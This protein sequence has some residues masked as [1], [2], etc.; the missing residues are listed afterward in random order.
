MV[1]SNVPPPSSRSVSFDWNNVVEP[2]L[3]SVAPF[4]IRVGVNSTNI[5]L[6]MVNEG[7][8]ASIISSLTWKALGSPKLLVVDNQ[9]LAYDRKPGESMRVLPQFPITLGGKTVL[10]NMMVVDCPLDFN[11]LL[12]CDFVYAM[13]VVVSSL[14]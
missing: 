9:F 12:E 4:Q 10:I 3:P 7:S 14:F 8:S 2:H 6:C 13:N 1:A 11:M 5:Y